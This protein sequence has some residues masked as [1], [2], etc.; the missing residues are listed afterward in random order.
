MFYRGRPGIKKV[1]WDA[2]RG[3]KG[4]RI[5]S[6]ESTKSIEAKLGYFSMADGRNWQRTFNKS[7]IILE[8][9]FGER[10]LKSFERLEAKDLRDY[11]SRLVITTMLPDALMDFDADMFCYGDSLAI[12]LISQDM[13][14]V[15]NNNEVARTFRFLFRII[16]QLGKKFDL[17]AYVKELFTEARRKNNA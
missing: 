13:V 2:L 3:L 9:I 5:Y 10:G 4:S 14:I 16:Q 6:I 1:Y 15:I 8:T 12:I 11:T 7:G 17:N